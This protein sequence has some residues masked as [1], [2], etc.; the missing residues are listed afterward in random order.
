MDLFRLEQAL[1]V[2]WGQHAA[3]GAHETPARAIAALTTE[4]NKPHLACNPSWLRHKTQNS[5]SRYSRTKLRICGRSSTIGMRF[6]AVRARM[7]LEASRK[8]PPT[9]VASYTAVHVNFIK[10]AGVSFPRIYPQTRI[11]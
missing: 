6:A 7:G 5:F 11:G 2:E 9:G 4:M 1:Q 10:Q 8:I 3:M